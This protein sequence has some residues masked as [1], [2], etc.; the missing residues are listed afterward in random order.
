MSRQAPLWLRIKSK[1]N[2]TKIGKLNLRNHIWW[3]NIRNKYA[4]KVIF[5]LNQHPLLTYL[6]NGSRAVIFII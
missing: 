6:K 2:N 5:Y 4:H 1:F 3:E